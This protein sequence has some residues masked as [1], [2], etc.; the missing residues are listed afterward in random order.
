MLPTSSAAACRIFDTFAGKPIFELDV[1]SF[2]PTKVAQAF[3][4]HAKVGLPDFVC[5][6][7]THQ[8][9]DTARLITLLRKGVKRPRRYGAADKSH[10]LAPPHLQPPKLR[11]R[12]VSI[13]FAGLK[14]RSPL[15]GCSKNQGQLSRQI[16]SLQRTRNERG[17]KRLWCIGAPDLGARQ[18]TQE[19]FMDWNRVE[20]NWKQLKGSVKEKW[21]NLTD[22]DLDK[23]AGR[24]DQLEGVIQERY[25]I[26]KDQVRKDIDTWLGSQT[27]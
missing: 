14:G 7:K 13:S 20:G 4:E 1:L 22:D 5:F 19:V 17:P 24:R 8:Y 9:A 12:I 3:P 10:K 18:M 15:R 11:Q 21:G 16:L 26:A 2:G 23:V 25:G 6:G 27:I